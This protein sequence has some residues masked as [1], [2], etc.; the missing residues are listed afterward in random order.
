MPKYSVR[1]YWSYVDEYEVEAESPEEAVTLAQAYDCAKDF[2]KPVELA[3]LA[4]KVEHV[5]QHEY[6]DHDDTMV[7][8]LDEAGN[9]IDA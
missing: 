2:P 5:T 7:N 4:R 8:E 3:A 6:V 9:W 1:M